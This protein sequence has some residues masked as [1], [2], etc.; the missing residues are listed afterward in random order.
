MIPHSIDY[1]QVL[2]N[3]QV[4]PDTG[5]SSQEAAQRLND[6][7]ENKLQEKKKKSSVKRF[8]VICSDKTGTL[9]QNQM[10]LVK[11]FEANNSI[12][13]DISDSNSDPRNNQGDGSCGCMS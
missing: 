7:G 1:R 10:T 11:A 6:Y 13:E 3:L 12:L 2:K 8:A 9:T 4:N 5:L